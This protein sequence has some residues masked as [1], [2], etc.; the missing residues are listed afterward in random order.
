MPKIEI[1]R[2]SCIKGYWGIP[3]GLNGP[4]WVTGADM[5]RYYISQQEGREV[6]L[7]GFRRLSFEFSSNNPGE[8]FEDGALGKV[9][10]I[11]EFKR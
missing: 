7:H 11:Y 9:T 3:D 10:I 5:M 1:L 6:N 2:P 8:A 4:E